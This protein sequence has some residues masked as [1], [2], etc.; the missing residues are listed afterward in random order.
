L[1]WSAFILK[2]LNYPNNNHASLVSIGQRGRVMTS[3]STLIPLF[4]IKRARCF[5]IKAG[6]SKLVIVIAPCTHHLCFL[7]VFIVLG[8]CSGACS[9]I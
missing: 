2:D 4:M 8:S 9:A 6:K 5:L 1:P 7:V 3:L